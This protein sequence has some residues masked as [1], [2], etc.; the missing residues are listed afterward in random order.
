MAREEIGKTGGFIALITVLL[1]MIILLAV[2]GLVVVNTLKGSP[3]GT[4]TIAATMPTAILMGLYL[5]YWRPGRVMEASLIGFVLIVAG[6]FGGQAVHE[7]ATWAPYFTYSGL[8]LCF[9]LIIYGFLASALPVWLLLAPRDYFEHLRETGC[10]RHAGSGHHLIKAAITDAA[11]D[12]FRR[13]YRTHLRWKD[14]SVLLHH[15]RLRGRFGFPC[16]DLIR[17]DAEVAC[18]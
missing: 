11:S 3:W 18:A 17:H 12:P 13:R 10:R 6:I 9:A 5:R 8:A 15:H 2:I 7:S 1:I 14:F 16:P 4:F